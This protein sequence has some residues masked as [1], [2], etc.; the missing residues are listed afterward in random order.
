MVRG[1]VAGRLFMA[2]GSSGPRLA[3][4]VGGGGV[5]LMGYV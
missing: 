1:V 5:K 2:L 4:G 3:G